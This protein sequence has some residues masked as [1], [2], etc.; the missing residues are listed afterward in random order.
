MN[1]R[2]QN[3]VVVVTGASSGIGR[4]TALA[5]AR[6]GARVV[7]AGRNET[8]LQEVAD[9][10]AR[11][12]GKAL[13]IPTDVTKEDDVHRL[14]RTVA[15]Q[16]GRLDIL[17]NNAGIGLRAAVADTHPEDAQRVMDVNF[18]GALRCIQAA[19]P[20]MKRQEPARSRAPRA[21]IVNVG[22]VLSV[23]A[24]PR[25]SLYS[26]SKFAL[27]ALSD[28]LRIELKSDG[29]DVIL[30]MPG[31]TDTPFFDNV[32]R[33]D[34]SPRVASLKG[35][36]PSKVACA[37]L[38]ACARRKREVVHSV[39]GMLGVWTK[40]WLPGILDRALARSRHDP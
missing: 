24:T 6:A 13:L 7:L 1:A 30:I 31:Y 35:Q 19:L 5:F 22:S 3:K 10:I 36:H 17:V 29:I 33:Y 28:A 11:G 16:F 38:R 37:I 4:E 21:Q 39:P 18:F 20:V 8:R 14:F 34:G 9:A 12:T 40:R 32:I 2:F 27:R 15:D 25:N 26:A 23:I